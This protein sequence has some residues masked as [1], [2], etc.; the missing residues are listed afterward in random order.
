[1]TTVASPKI[2]TLRGE[3]IEIGRANIGQAFCLALRLS[4]GPDRP[5][6]HVINVKIKDVRSR[7]GVCGIERRNAENED[8]EEFHRS[9]GLSLFLF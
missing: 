4:V 1:M 5:P 9:I 8:E 7:G 6:T 2:H 3:P